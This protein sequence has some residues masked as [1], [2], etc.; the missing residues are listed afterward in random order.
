MASHVHLNDQIMKAY[1]NGADRMAVKA[2]FGLRNNQM[3]GVSSRLGLLWSLPLEARRQR[4]EA[5][6]RGETLAPAPK[7]PKAK[8]AKR[9]PKALAPKPLPT[10]RYRHGHMGSHNRLINSLLKVK[11][12]EE[13][14]P[15][16][17]PTGEVSEVIP[18]SNER[19]RHSHGRSTFLSEREKRLRGIS[20]RECSRAM[21]EP[22]AELS[23]DDVEYLERY[24]EASLQSA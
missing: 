23:R 8:R 10:P 21:P 14:A 18:G 5:I 9:A 4:V 22:S 24:I 11:D 16:P 19:L 7:K 2:E 15:I 6:E 1:L 20:S 3:S 13:S 12:K 17:E